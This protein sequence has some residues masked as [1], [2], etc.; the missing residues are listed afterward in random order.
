MSQPIGSA[1]SDPAL[2]YMIRH[3]ME[4]SVD[5]YLDYIFPGEIPEDIS[6]AEVVPRELW[7][8][9]DHV[10]DPTVSSLVGQSRQPVAQSLPASG[11]SS[12]GP[13]G[14]APAIPAPSSLPIA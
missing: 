6:L 3:G 10:V 8:S 13:S 11:L 9:E 4:I 14:I 7:F 5:E 12:L 2:D 1:S